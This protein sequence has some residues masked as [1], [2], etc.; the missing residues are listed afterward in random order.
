MNLKSYNKGAFVWIIILSALLACSSDNDKKLWDETILVNT[1]AS[2][3][4][5]LSQFPSGKYSDNANDKI[6]DLLFEQGNKG[7]NVLPVY[8]QYVKKYPSGKY[9]GQFETLLFEQAKVKNTIASFEEYAKRFPKGKYLG[10]VETLLYDAI[11]SGESDMSYGEYLVRFPESTHMVE[12]EQL[13]YDSVLR[14]Q[15]TAIADTYLV[16]FPEG[17]HVEDVDLMVEGFYYDNCVK[18]NSHYSIMAFLNKFP[19]S[20]HVKRMFFNID[21]VGAKLTVTDTVNGII[22][23]GAIPDTLLVVENTILSFAIEKEGFLPFYEQYR[24]TADSSQVFKPQLKSVI[25]Y[26]YQNDFSKTGSPYVGNSSKFKFELNDNSNLYCKTSEKQFQKLETFSI[27]FTKDFIL[28]VRFKFMNPTNYSKS[29]FGFV[30]GSKTKVRY[31]FATIDGRLGFGDQK[32]SFI[33]SD[34]NFGYSQWSADGGKNDNWMAFSSFKQNDYNVLR[35]EKSGKSYI[36]T[37]N[38]AIFHKDNV[39]SRLAGDNVGFGI[40]NSEVLVDYFNIQQ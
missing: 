13:M 39:F 36:Y 35:I 2:Y 4:S 38:G 28:E 33:S 6:Q 1:T 12:I 25:N 14:V 29:Y 30:W 17:Q 26:L 37:L 32:N 11:I 3:E 8:D 20:G 27:D 31:Y 19:R 22:Y 15:T 10:E 40:G 18:R 16:Y 24:V 9:L 23:N 5:Y 34:N 7:A 21:T